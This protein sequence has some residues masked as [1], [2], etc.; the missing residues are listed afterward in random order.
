MNKKLEAADV[1]K[2]QFMFEEVLKASCDSSFLIGG[3]VRD[4]LAIGQEAANPFG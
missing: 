4:R 3:G 2:G 1:G